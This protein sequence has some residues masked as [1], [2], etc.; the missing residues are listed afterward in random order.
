MQD[1]EVSRTIFELPTKL[2]ARFH[3]RCRELGHSGKF[4]IMG[5]IDDW[6]NSQAKPA[7]KKRKPTRQPAIIRLP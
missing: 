2:K 7:A 3:S 1:Q 4:V 5:L 6:L